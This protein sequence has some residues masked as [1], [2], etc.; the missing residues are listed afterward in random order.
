MITAAPVAITNTAIAKALA[1]ARWLI[2]NH[3]WR[4]IVGDTR[5]GFSADGAILA[6]ADTHNGLH[7]AVR[8]VFQDVIGGYEIGPWNDV[9]GRSKDEVLG[10]FLDAEGL[11]RTGIQ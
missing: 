1:D 4:L 9:F 8:R 3:G 6:A 2:A 7:L 5:Q 11:M 10:K